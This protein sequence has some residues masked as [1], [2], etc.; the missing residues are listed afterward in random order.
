[1]TLKEEAFSSYCLLILALPHLLPSVINLKLYQ[2]F[3]I[4]IRNVGDARYS[5]AIDENCG[6]LIYV[7]RRSQRLRFLDAGIRL[8]R[9]CAGRDFLCIV[10][11]SSGEFLQFVIGCGQCDTALIFEN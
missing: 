7:Q 3:Q 9:S 1:M 6:R 10:A 11:S 5:A 8:W 2:L 4:V